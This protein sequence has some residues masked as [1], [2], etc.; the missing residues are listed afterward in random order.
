MAPIS[1]EFSNGVLPTKAAKQQ[2]YQGSLAKDVPL[3]SS[4]NLSQVEPYKLEK[5]LLN[6][7]ANALGPVNVPVYIYRSS[8]PGPTIGLTSAIHGNEVNG[9]AV[10]QQIFSKLESEYSQT[11]EKTFEGAIIGVPVLNV[12]GFLDSIRSFDGQD[13]N[14]LMPG[15]ADGAAPQQ[16][17]YKLFHEVILKFDYVFDLHTASAGRQNSLYVRA[18]M[19]HSEI[20]QMARSLGSQII[21]HNSSPGGSLRGCAQANGIKAITIEIGNPSI[22]QEKLIKKVISGISNA[23]TVPLGHQLLQ[24]TN[25]KISEAATAVCYRSYWVFSQKAGILRVYKQV[26]ESMRRGELIAEVRSIFGEV[27][28]QIFSPMDQDTV[29][30]GIEA[31]PVAKT[32]NRIVSTH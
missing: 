11:G 23:L 10:I 2:P 4:L 29:V 30:V 25:P 22:F 31:N 12:P 7:S 5:R 21:V 19:T 1:T 13:L 16:Y 24:D 18:D 15:K 20:S 3:I 28:E 17:A 9:V 27:I 32:G 6:I 8:I 14:R 26:A